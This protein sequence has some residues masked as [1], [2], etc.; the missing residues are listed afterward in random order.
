MPQLPEEARK[1]LDAPNFATVT[2]INPDG[3]PQST[4]VWVRTDGDD[5]IFSTAKGRRKPLNF[6]RDPRASLLVI[7]PDDP[8]RYVEVRGRVT[9]TPDP[10]G[11]LIE[12]LSQKYRGQSW[13]DKPGVERLIVRIRPDRV[14]LRG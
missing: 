5:V 8:Y 14:T 2:S 13:E 9:M 3:G 4:V 12:E 7:D 11:A 1:L 10:T 6:E